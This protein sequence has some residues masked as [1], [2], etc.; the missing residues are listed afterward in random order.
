MGFS[1]HLLMEKLANF[2]TKNVDLV[3]ILSMDPLDISR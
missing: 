2:S 1:V 3:T